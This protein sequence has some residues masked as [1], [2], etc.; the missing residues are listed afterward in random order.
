MSRKGVKKLVL[1]STTSM[2]VTKDSKEAILVDAKELERVTCTWYPIAFLGDVIQDDS[3]LD[4]VLAILDSGSEVNEMHPAFAEKFGLVVWTTNV[5]AQKIDST[6]FETYEMVVAA[7]LVT[8]QS[9]R[10]RFFKEIFLVA[11]IS[12]NI[13]FGIL[14][15]SLSGVNIDFPKKELW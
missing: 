3:S 4:P 11:N 14:F 15:L 8:D 7:F 2:S 1:V 5:G 9:N 10:V 6:I 12:P 13:V